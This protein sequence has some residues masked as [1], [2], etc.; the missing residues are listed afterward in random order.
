[1]VWEGYR[2]RLCK[3]NNFNENGLFGRDKCEGCMVVNKICSWLTSGYQPIYAISRSRPGE[4]K[5][6]DYRSSVV[7][8]VLFLRTPERREQRTS[9]SEH[10]VRD[11]TQGAI[12]KA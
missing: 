11:S 7:E 6:P 1:M 2:S 9:G 10:S 8:T 4:I 3:C 5:S 12:K